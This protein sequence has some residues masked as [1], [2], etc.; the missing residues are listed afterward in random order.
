VKK[1]DWEIRPQRVVSSALAICVFASFDVA[2]Q[3]AAGTW[4]EIVSVGVEFGVVEEGQT[5]SQPEID[6]E[7]IQLSLAGLR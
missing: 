7:E 5:G 1:W 4:I 6:L 3:G 2:P